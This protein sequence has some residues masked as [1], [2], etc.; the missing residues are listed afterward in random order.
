MKSFQK[1]VAVLLTAIILISAVSCTPISLTKQWSYKYND[2]VLTTQQDIG[3]YIYALYQAYNA[4]SSYAQEAKGYKEGESFLDLKIKDDDG[5]KAIAREWILEEA[6]KIAVNIIATDY[7]VEKHDAK[8]D[9]AEMASAKTTAKDTWEVGPQEYVSMGYY[10]PMSKELEKHGISFESFFAGSYAANVKQT[11]LFEKL[12]AKGGD[13]E[14]T[15]KELTKFFTEEYVNY[16]FIPVHLHDETTDEDGN[17]KAT[18]FKDKKIKEIEKYIDGIVAEINN[19]S[20]TATKAFDTVAKKYS[21]EETEI[22]KNTVEYF[23]DTEANNA[24]IAKALKKLKTGK[25]TQVTVNAD[26][27]SPETYIVVKNDINDSVKDYIKNEDK[28]NQVL[29]NCKKDD[30]TDYIEETTKAL[31]K[32]EAL[33]ANTAVIDR[34][35]PD[36][37]YVKPEATTEETAA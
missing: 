24:D 26:G 5:D 36:M 3:V 18:P 13:E 21:V 32:S 11:A 23:A 35:K 2:S 14:V 25:A 27:D 8:Y 4:A 34:Y 31:I 29:S 19:G 10:M 9:E 28:R 12:Y 30:L 6:E 17:T 15:D 16:S 20:M 33:S 22:K 37:F 7:L 1:V